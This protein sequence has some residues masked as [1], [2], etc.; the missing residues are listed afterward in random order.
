MTP[1]QPKWQL[2]TISDSKTP[3]APNQQNATQETKPPQ[4]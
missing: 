3:Q 1:T 2:E 4:K